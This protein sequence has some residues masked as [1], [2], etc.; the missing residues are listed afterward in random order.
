MVVRL[1]TLAI[2]CAAA[3]VSAASAGNVD[4]RALVLQQ[5]DVPA[6]FERDHAQ[7]G[8]LPNDDVRFSD[9]KAFVTRSG[10]V[11]GYLA[12]FVERDRGIGLQ[13][14][15]DLFRRPAGARMMLA[16]VYDRWQQLASTDPY[17]RVRIGTEGWVFGG[18]VD[19]IV[20]WRSGRTFAWVLGV[21]MTRQPT[22]ALARKQ[23]RR[24][25]AVLR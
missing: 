3:L 18:P 7:S 8:A 15:V 13:S 23:Q 19:T 25:A 2:V 6:G 9:A 11:G 17:G 20:F 14:R 16:R 10:R 21:N 24:I 4:P 12:Q 22:L 1:A 5:R